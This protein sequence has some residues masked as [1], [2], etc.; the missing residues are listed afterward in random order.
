MRLWRWRV[1]HQSRWGRRREQRPGVR[2]ERGVGFRGKSGRW[3][4][5][6]CKPR[7][8]RVVLVG[9]RLQQLRNERPVELRQRLRIDR[10]LRQLGF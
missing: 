2:V 8:E 6:R 1:N 10:E 4:R 3:F 5:G 9:R 7:L